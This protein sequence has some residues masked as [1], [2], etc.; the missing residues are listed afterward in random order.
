MLKCAD[1]FVDSCEKAK[2]VLESNIFKY[3]GGLYVAQE[4]EAGTEEEDEEAYQLIEKRNEKLDEHITN[5]LKAIHSAISIHLEKLTLSGVKANPEDLG[6][7]ICRIKSVELDGIRLTA[8][9]M[10]K[11]YKK[12][13][14]CESLALKDLTY[15]ATASMNFFCHEDVLGKTNPKL[16]AS[17]AIRMESLKAMVDSRVAT[18]VLD[19]IINCSDIKLQKLKLGNISNKIFLSTFFL[20]KV[21]F[22]WVLSLSQF[23]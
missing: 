11:V 10:K 19:K 13:I 21:L 23:Y 15:M 4:Y 22:N 7:A 2:D 1:V 6:R 9:E 12:I 18:A 17:V 3:V 14:A 16:F 8:S 20:V 5:I